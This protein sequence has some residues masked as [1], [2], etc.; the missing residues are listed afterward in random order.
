M[1]EAAH[2]LGGMLHPAPHAPDTA[3][4][5]MYARV[6]CPQ[7]NTHIC[8]DWSGWCPHRCGWCQCR[9]CPQGSKP[10]HQ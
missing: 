10:A 6:A 5:G 2:K 9:G 4:L 7:Q 8:R 3:C 1:H